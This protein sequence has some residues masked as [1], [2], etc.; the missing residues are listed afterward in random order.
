MSFTVAIKAGAA[1]SQGTEDEQDM[2]FW[3]K[4]E[5]HSK[6]SIDAQPFTLG[7]G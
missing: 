3:E 5:S 2:S 1:P 6:G 7:P 4:Y